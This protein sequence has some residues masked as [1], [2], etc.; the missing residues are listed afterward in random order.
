MMINGEYSLG[1]AKKL[2]EQLAEGKYATPDEML[3]AAFRLAWGRPPTESELS[4]ALRFIAA[5][6]AEE[7]WTFDR[8]RLV[9]FCHVLFNSNEFLYVE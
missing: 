1:R 4:S 6:L 5:A 9:D 3:S 7:Q 2:A 8:D